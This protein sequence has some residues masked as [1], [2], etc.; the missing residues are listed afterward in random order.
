L[1]EFEHDP[2]RERVK[3]GIAA[4]NARGQISGRLPGYRPSDRF[5]PRVV[6]LSEA[7]YSQRQIA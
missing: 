7:G 6:E 3:R 4:A 1:A 2:L 5:A